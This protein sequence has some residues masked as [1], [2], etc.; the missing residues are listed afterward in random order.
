MFAAHLSRRLAER[1]PSTHCG[2]S[3]WVTKLRPMTSNMRFAAISFLVG[4][5]CLAAGFYAGRASNPLR[6]LAS[7]AARAAEPK[8]DAEAKHALYLSYPNVQDAMRRWAAKQGSS[9]E[10]AMEGRII[11]MM[12]FPDRE[13]IQFGID[14]AS[15]GGVPIYCYRF[16]TSDLGPRRATELVYENSDVE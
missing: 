5:V 6:E 12:H 15:V 9:V 3:V 13:C 16:D 10:K 7:D 8:T 2:H 14:L 1:L 11:E 4:A